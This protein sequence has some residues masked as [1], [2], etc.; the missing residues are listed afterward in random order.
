MP[1]RCCSASK[2]SK[3]CQRPDEQKINELLKEAK[4]L[5]LKKADGPNGFDDIDDWKKGWLEAFEHH[6]F[7]CTE[8]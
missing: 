3:G 5:I 4:D 6:L 2:P 8:K 1:C 7:G